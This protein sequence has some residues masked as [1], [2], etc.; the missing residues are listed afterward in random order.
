MPSLHPPA[1]RR[2]GPGG[3]ARP[4]RADRIEAARGPPRR[5]AGP[6]PPPERREAGG[7][8]GGERGSGRARAS[9]DRGEDG[10]PP[11]T[12]RA[13]PPEGGRGRT[14]APGSRV[15]RAGVGQGCV[16][17]EGRPVRC[18]RSQA[19][20]GDPPGPRPARPRQGTGGAGRGGGRGR[21]P[22]VP[23]GDGNGGTGARGRT[24][25]TRVPL[26]AAR[27]NPRGQA[28]RP[29]PGGGPRRRPGPAGPARGRQDPT[30]HGEAAGPPRGRGG[31]GGPG[32]Q[33][34]GHLERGRRAGPP[35][36]RG[37]AAARAPAPRSGGRAPGG[38][39]STPRP[40]CCIAGSDAVGA[41]WRRPPPGPGE[42][43]RGPGPPGAPSRRGR[44]RGDGGGS[45]HGG[46]DGRRR[47]P[48][49]GRRRRAPP[50]DS[51]RGARSGDLLSDR[52]TPS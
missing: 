9:G 34:G 1:R 24:P 35:S 23:A 26:R 37:R 27:P 5:G 12:A 20:P 21:G 36:S 49:T 28:A 10:A 13:R 30:C 29:A 18:I 16:L 40:R 43:A 8:A 3:P 47:T 15:A 41:A 33:R 4:V 50:L 32:G 17:R 31:K 52:L 6:N 2:A 25:P 22:M 42:H 39:D 14:A 48:S 46:G 44:A 51:H 7:V 19:S 11:G 45:R 38:T